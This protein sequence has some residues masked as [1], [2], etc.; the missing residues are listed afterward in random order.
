MSDEPFSF[1]ISLFVCLLIEL[2]LLNKYVTLQ[3]SVCMSP[4]ADLRT[5][6]ATCLSF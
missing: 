4:E 3:Q 2:S 1:I 5:L 6:A